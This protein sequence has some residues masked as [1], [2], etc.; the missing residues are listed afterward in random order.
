MLEFLYTDTVNLDM[1]PHAAY[2]LLLTANLYSIERLCCLCE[3]RGN[4]FPP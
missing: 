2:D 3:V 1:D 4:C